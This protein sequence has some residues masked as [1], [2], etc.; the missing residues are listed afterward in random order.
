MKVRLVTDGLTSYDLK[1]DL[2]WMVDFEE[3]EAPQPKTNFVDIPARSGYLDLTEVDG[4]IY[5]NAVNFVLVCRRICSKSDLILQYSRQM[6]N[7]FNG[8]Q[9]RV[10]LNEDTYYY[11]ARVSV[12]N[13]YRDGLVLGLE[14][15]V[16]AFPYRLEANPTEKTFTISGSKTI[17]LDNDDMP[18]VPT[19]SA[20]AAMTIA[21]QGT[22]ASYSIQAG[23]NIILPNLVIPAGGISLD[24]T[25]T[26]TIG[27]TYTKGAF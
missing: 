7:L 14:L 1:S 3:M 9:L 4:T 23:S 13:F 17:S 2:G 22:G 11:D 6:M 24:I 8:K 25:G 19:I 10:F 20:S 21:N 12:G 18:V 16:S 5:Y 26:G 27:F 15:N